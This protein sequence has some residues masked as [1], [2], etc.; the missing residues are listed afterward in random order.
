MRRIATAVITGSLLLVTSA[1]AN[2]EEHW[3]VAG[4]AGTTGLGAN[5][6][7]RFHDHFA[8][9]AGYSGYNYDDLDHTNGDVTYKGEVDMDIYSLKLDIYPWVNS[10]FFISAGAVKPDVQLRA[11]G[12]Y[13]GDDTFDDIGGLSLDP[14]SARLNGHGKLSDSVEP[15]LGIG[16]RNSSKQGLGFYAEAGAFWIDPSVSLTP[17]GEAFDNPATG[18]TARQ[19]AE[20]YVREQEDDL[21][22]ELNKYNIYPVAVIGIE[23]TF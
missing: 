10:G 19:L 16:W 4:S 17:R 12:R 5:V 3:S 6:S 20:P 8:L 11:V 13:T 15:Y 2:A 22:D 23:Y 9:T 18:A 1:A 7:W 14:D 21:R